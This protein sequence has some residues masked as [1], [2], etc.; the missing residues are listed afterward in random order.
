MRGGM[1]VALLLIGQLAWADGPTA[2]QHFEQGSRLYDL[3]RFHEAA[4]EYEAAYELH[5]D[6]ALLFNIGQAYRLG[7]EP[8]R[9][10]L[11]FRSYLRRVPDAPNRTEVEARIA[12]LQELVS[13]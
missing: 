3:Q 12:Q 5:P 4:H 6:P 13:Q 8:D 9:A 2:R 10:L 7:N 11:A 1:T